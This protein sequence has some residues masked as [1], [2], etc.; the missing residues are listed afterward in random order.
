MDFSEFRECAEETATWIE[1]YFDNVE[2]YSVTSSISPGEGLQEL[3]CHDPEDGVSLKQL[4]ADFKSH[5]VPGLTHWAHPGFFNYFNSSSSEPAV[6]TEMLAAAVNV[7][8]MLWRSAP[9]AT[10]LEQTTL[11]WLSQWMGLTGEW[12]GILH[13]TGSLSN[14]HALVAARQWIAPDYRNQG[15]QGD[16]VVYAS[17]QAHSSIMRGA[18]AAGFGANQV[19]LIETNDVFSMRTD[20]LEST[21]EADIQRGLRPCC[22]V[23]AIGSTA[24]CAIDS[25]PEITAI[26]Q[27]HR[28]WLHADCAYGGALAIVPEYR[29]LFSG[30]ETVDS[31]VINPHKWLFVP[32]DCSVLYTRHPATLRQAFS[33]IPSYLE[34]SET[35]INYM[36]YGIALTRRFRALKLWFV[37]RAFG[38]KAIVEHLRHHL[39]F[40]HWLANQVNVDPAF[41]LVAPVTMGL[42]CLR[43]RGGNELTQ[44]LVDRVNATGRFWLGTTELNE[45]LVI[46]VAI[47]NLRVEKRHVEELWN[48]LKKQAEYGG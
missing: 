29:S 38:R 6:L 44:M 7:N 12:F 5:I 1:R 46:R 11:A 28:I 36:D 18:I 32:I 41:E 17:K 48:E 35:A 43:L 47:G 40:S 15:M 19:R 21:I 20:I 23:A 14:F 25:L 9:I 33:Y 30:L 16:L 8:V 10:E 31:L 13:E 37:M 42:V 26:A 3:L 22:I 24:S 2:Q 27:K 45:Q 39:E 4:F 34:T